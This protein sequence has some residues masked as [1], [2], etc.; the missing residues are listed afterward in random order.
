MRKNSAIA[1]YLF[2]SLARGTAGPL[3]DIDLAVIFP[4]NM[5]RE[6]QESRVEY[7]RESLEKTYGIDKV[8]VV[9]LDTMANPFIRYTAMFNDGVLLFNDDKVLTNMIAF[10]AM[11]EYEDTSIIRRNQRNALKHLFAHQ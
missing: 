5:P 9:N 3:S 10:R 6:V 11:R 8:D 1:G 7:I 4:M 2:G